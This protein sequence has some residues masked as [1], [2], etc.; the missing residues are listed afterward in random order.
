M[1]SDLWL[2]LQDAGRRFF[3]GFHTWLM[4]GVDIDERSVES[5]GPLIK[6]DQRTNI[7]RIHFR[8]GDRDRVTP[9]FVEGRAGPAKEA[10]KI[11]SARH[12]FFDF[13]FFASAIF[14][15]LQK[16]GEK[17]GHAIA[18]LLHVSMLIGRSLVS[19]NCDPLM[20][21]VAVV[22]LLLA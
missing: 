9:V 1:R 4:I 16:R 18:Q 13:E 14:S 7:K 12:A 3:P 11:I 10:L 6:R 19:V 17:V 2:Q 21:N 20:D 8:N 22:V 5:N 15:H